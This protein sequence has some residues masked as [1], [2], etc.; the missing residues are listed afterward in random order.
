MVFAVPLTPRSKLSVTVLDT[1]KNPT[2]SRRA[3]QE[4]NC[5]SLPIGDGQDLAVGVYQ[6]EHVHP[7]T[8][9]T[10]AHQVRDD[11]GGRHERAARRTEA[12]DRFLEDPVAELLPCRFEDLGCSDHKRKKPTAKTVGFSSELRGASTTIPFAP[13]ALYVWGEE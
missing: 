6:D 1:K 9:A 10:A 5:L 13:Y 3:S 12:L 11:Q 2:L 4:K 7:A 8:R